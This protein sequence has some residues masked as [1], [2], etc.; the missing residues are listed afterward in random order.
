MY[1]IISSSH[2]IIF[3]L[4]K[5]EHFKWSFQLE[6]CKFGWILYIWWFLHRPLKLLNLKIFVKFKKSY[7]CSDFELLKFSSLITWEL[8]SYNISLPLLWNL[9]SVVFSRDSSNATLV[10][11]YVWTYLKESHIHAWFWVYV[12]FWPTLWV[13]ILVAGLTYAFFFPFLRL[14]S[15]L[16]VCVQG[17]RAV[18]PSMTLCQ[19]TMESW[20]STRG[21]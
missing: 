8:I 1:G 10:T 16:H 2:Y 14:S 3:D 6:V 7:R 15:S 12:S 21:K 11:P 17:S 19:K 20:V 9:P 18:K 13:F 4:F 5:I